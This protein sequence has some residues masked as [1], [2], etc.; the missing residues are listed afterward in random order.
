MAAKVADALGFEEY[1]A[2]LFGPRWP[3]LREALSVRGPQVNLRRRYGL[4]GDYW[5]DPA[6]CFLADLLRG[7]IGSFDP[8]DPSAEV[9]DMCAAPGGKFLSLALSLPQGFRLRAT[10]VSS[11]RF[12]RLRQQAALL[13]SAWLA[14]RIALFRGDAC[15]LA[16]RYKTG[17]LFAA[18]LLDAPCSSERHVLSQAKARPERLREWRA[19]RSKRNARNQLALLCGALDCLAPGGCLLYATCAL[20]PWENAEVVARALH[21][22]AFLNMVPCALQP[23]SYPAWNCEPQFACVSPTSRKDSV[24]RNPSVGCKRSVPCNPSVRCEGSVPCEG[25]HLGYSILPDRNQGSGPLYFC[26]LRRPV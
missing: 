21:K 22:R 15:K 20:S 1:Y 24:S 14:E 19:S 26:L 25:V 10:E 8:F 9:W 2:G 13:P 18:I 16:L 3:S 7:A 5:L 4:D 12:T 23:E 11:A 6:S 17:P